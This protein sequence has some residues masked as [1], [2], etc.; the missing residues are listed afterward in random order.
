MAYNQYKILAYKELSRDKFEIVSV[1]IDAEKEIWQKQISNEVFKWPQLIDTQMWKGV[2]VT[3]LKF[4][5][6]PFNFL[7]SPE[8]RI[9]NKA[10]KP[11]SLLTILAKAIH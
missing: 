1:A 7:V 5:S 6:I 8:G 10:I 3:T 11:D 4:D 9:I 2:A